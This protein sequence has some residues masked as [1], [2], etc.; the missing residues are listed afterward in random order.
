MEQ[1][2]LEK[3]RGCVMR[4]H[5]ARPRL[6]YWLLLLGVGEKECA[7]ARRRRRIGE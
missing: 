1:V 3:F 7:R 4:R 5:A 6:A 2:D